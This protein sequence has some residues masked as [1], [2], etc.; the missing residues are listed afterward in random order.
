MIVSGIKAEG[1]DIAA[2]RKV[3]AAAKAGADLRRVI[4]V[5]MSREVEIPIVVRDLDDGGFG[6]RFQV[7]GLLLHEVFERLRVVPHLV[8]Q[9][10]VDPR[11]GAADPERM[12]FLS[13][14]LG[15]HRFRA[16]RR[17]LG[18]DP[19]TGRPNQQPRAHGESTDW[20]T[21]RISAG[22]DDTSPD[23]FALV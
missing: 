5:A 14:L 23:R 13:G 1:D 21:H 10:S 6:R 3:V 7:V 22:D 19:A 9:P 12:Q 8:V 4:R 11:G 17:T 20:S 18:E 16:R 15:N 2:L